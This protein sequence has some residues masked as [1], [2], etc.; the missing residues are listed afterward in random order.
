MSENPA[1]KPLL[2]LE[3][4]LPLW[5]CVLFLLNLFFWLASHC[6]P[7]ECREISWRYNDTLGHWIRPWAVYCLLLSLLGMAIFGLS[8]LFRRAPLWLKRTCGI[9]CLTGIFLFLLPSN[10]VQL[11][12]RLDFS[13]AYTLR[14]Q[15]IGLAHGVE[16][17]VRP[18]SGGMVSVDLDNLDDYDRVNSLLPPNAPDDGRWGCGKYKIFHGGPRQ[19][20]G[21]GFKIEVYK[22]HRGLFGIRWQENSGGYRLPSSRVP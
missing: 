10:I 18:D 8:A 12:N 9:L 2:R 14:G 11:N 15:A 16:L 3:R 21:G 22:V 17:M 4:N 20:P 13:P 6:F 19:L 5:F 1:P 7:F